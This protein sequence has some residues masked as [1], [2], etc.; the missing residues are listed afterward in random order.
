MITNEQELD[1]EITST[2]I[3]YSDCVESM[4]QQ[5]IEFEENDQFELA[6]YTLDK[7]D[8]IHQQ[9][10]AGFTSAFRGTNIDVKMKLDE[11]RA[12]VER[13]TRENK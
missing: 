5:I 12:D 13:Y 4:T 2:L 11:L 9:S 8:T 6:R 7:L 3:M 1:A 10:I